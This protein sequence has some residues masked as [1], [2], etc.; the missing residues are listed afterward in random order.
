VRDLAHWAAPLGELARR[1]L[2]QDLVAR[3]PQGAVVFPDSPKPP[4]AHGIVVDLLAFDGATL[5]ASWSVLP[6]TRGGAL[7]QREVRLSAS[8]GG[9]PDAQPAAL[10]ALLGQL[11]DRI[12]ADLAS[13]PP[14]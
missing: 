9:G 14:A 7:R 8:A 4:G 6:A 2:T 3:L 10:S 13:A 11:A 12:A 1:A 5:D